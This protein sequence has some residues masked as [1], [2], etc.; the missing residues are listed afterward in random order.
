MKKRLDRASKC[1]QF[2]WVVK[3]EML[4]YLAWSWFHSTI[5]FVWLPLNKKARV[6]E[7]QIIADIFVLSLVFEERNKCIPKVRWI[8]TW[9]GGFPPCSFILARNIPRDIFQ[10]WEKIHSSDGLRIGRTV[11]AAPMLP[12]TK[13]LSF[14]LLYSSA[15]YEP[16]SLRHLV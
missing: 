9:E 11:G 6:L 12:S 4:Y 15:A 2:W 14:F 8:C 10:C 16:N 3:F 1:Q 7:S 13:L 5:W